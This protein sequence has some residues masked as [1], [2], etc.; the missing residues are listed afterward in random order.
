MRRSIISLIHKK[1]DKTDIENYRP[2]SLTNTDYR[3]LTFVLANRLQKV[4]KDIVS[5]DQES[6]IKDRFIA[7]NVRLVLDLFD[8]YNS[9]NDR[10]L[11]MFVD[12]KKS[13][14]SVEFEFLF[15]TIDKFNFGQDFQKWIKLLRIQPSAFVK[16]NGYLSEEINIYCGVRQGCPVSALLF[17][18]CMEVLSCHLRQNMNIRGLDIDGNKTK[19]IK[20]IQYADDATL[21]LRNVHEMREAILS[22]EKFGSVAGT[23]LNLT[24]CEVLWVGAYKTLQQSCTMCGIKWPTTPIRYLGIFIGHDSQLC[25]KLSF[26]SK[27]QI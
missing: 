24:K 17:I 8:L 7:T 10:G 25:Y 4:I 9:K 12:F 3:I 16:N 21:F 2:I 11:F 1:G 26:E 20:I 5:P 14:D 18:L 19:Q 23:Q 15:K 13:F 27:S 22:L 6:Y